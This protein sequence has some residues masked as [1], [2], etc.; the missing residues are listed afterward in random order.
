MF[1]PLKPYLIPGSSFVDGI[2]A[3]VF[4]VSVIWLYL[5]ILIYIHMSK[6]ENMKKQDIEMLFLFIFD[7]YVNI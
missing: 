7:K 6:Y 5:F 1:W 3:V 2:A 4:A